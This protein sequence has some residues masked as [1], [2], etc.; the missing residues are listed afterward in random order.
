MGL[1]AVA[2]DL[3]SKAIYEGT[4]QRL[5]LAPSENAYHVLQGEKVRLSSAI[6]ISAV[7][8]GEPVGEGMRQFYFFPNGVMLAGEIRISGREGY[9]SYVIRFDPLSGKV[10]VVKG[11]NQ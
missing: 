9:A 2:R 8:G 3:R 5:I 1:A 7:E 6:K 11:N 4:F 10:A